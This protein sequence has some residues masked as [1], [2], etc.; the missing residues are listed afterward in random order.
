MFHP[1]GQDFHLAEG[2]CN[3]LIGYPLDQTGGLPSSMLYLAN[4]NF[5]IPLPK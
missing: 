1:A 5:L 2:I 4:E 3:S